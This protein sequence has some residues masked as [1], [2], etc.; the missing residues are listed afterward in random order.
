MAFDDSL[1]TQ[2]VRE[3][4]TNNHTVQIAAANVAAARAQARIVGAAKWPQA[5]ATGS[6]SRSKREAPKPRRIRPD[7]N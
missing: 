6:G 2:L 7:K 5:S 4:L 1:A 3:A